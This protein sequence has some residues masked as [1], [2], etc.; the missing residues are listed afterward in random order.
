MDEMLE[1]ARECGPNVGCCSIPGTGITPA[2]RWPISAL[3]KR[4]TVDDAFRRHERSLS[5]ISSGGVWASHSPQCRFRPYAAQIS[6]RRAGVMPVPGIEQHPERSVRTRARIPA[7][8]PMRQMN[9]CGKRLR[10][11]ADRGIRGPSARAIGQY[12]GA[13][14]ES[15]LPQ[16]SQSGFGISLDEGIQVA[17]AGSRSRPRI[18]RPGSSFANPS[19]GR[20]VFAK[21]DRQIHDGRFQF[22]FAR[23]PA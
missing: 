13:G 15:G 1:F 22:S 12:V 17:C 9:S 8:R 10:I 18:A 6:H 21:L 4:P 23:T 3:R 2:R 16:L 11:A 19:G 7:S 5:T 14:L 20:V